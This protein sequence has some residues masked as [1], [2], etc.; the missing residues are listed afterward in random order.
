MKT[1]MEGNAVCIDGKRSFYHRT[2]H[3]FRTS[4]IGPL[5]SVAIWRVGKKGKAML[6]TLLHHPLL[7]RG[8]S[9]FVATMCA[10][11]LEITYD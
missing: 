3:D 7:G 5:L 1:A 10:E 9:A 8:C 6:L 2:E 11:D 4:S